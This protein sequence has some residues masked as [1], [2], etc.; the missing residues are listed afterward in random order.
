MWV[1]MG[2]VEDGLELE[3]LDRPS[4]SAFPAISL[5]FTILGETLAYVTSFFNPNIE[6]VTFRLR[7]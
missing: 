2:L 5:G 3:R 4:S 7:G 1:W 6:A